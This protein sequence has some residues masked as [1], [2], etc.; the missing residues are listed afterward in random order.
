MVVENA[1]CNRLKLPDGFDISELNLK[2]P[3]NSNETALYC[4]E[5]CTEYISMIDFRGNRFLNRVGFQ[6]E[7]NTLNRGDY[8]KRYKRDIFKRCMGFVKVAEDGLVP[9]VIRDGWF[10][11][12]SKDETNKDSFEMIANV[13]GDDLHKFRGWKI[14]S[15]SE[16]SETDKTVLRYCDYWEYTS[17]RMGMLM[18]KRKR[19][20]TYQDT[21]LTVVRD[22]MFIN[23]HLRAGDKRVFKDDYTYGDVSGLNL[24]DLNTQLTVPNDWKAAPEPAGNTLVL[25]RYT[26]TLYKRADLA[27]LQTD[28]IPRQGEVFTC[29]GFFH[30]TLHSD[31][32][33]EIFSNGTDTGTRSIGVRD[34]HVFIIETRVDLNNPDIPIPVFAGNVSQCPYQHEVILPHASMFRV[35]DAPSESIYQYVKTYQEYNVKTKKWEPKHA[36]IR[37]NVINLRLEYLG[38]SPTF[39][40]YISAGPITSQPEVNRLFNRIDE[41]KSSNP[42]HAPEK[43]FVPLHRQ[44]TDYYGGDATPMLAN[45][46]ATRNRLGLSFCVA[47]LSIAAS[48]WDDF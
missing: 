42:R 13:Y 30:T 21:V 22:F 7:D 9:I 16:S 4:N 35:I 38:V 24:E 25:Y 47:L 19:I 33:Y 23:A 1:K 39:N 46:R 37:E 12:V 28:N 6:T 36:T 10:Y 8:D 15:Y 18:P 5:G 43:Q 14:T 34:R 11:A 27:N 20:N 17:P 2:Q 45:P 26:N 31:R 41:Y 40:Q 3:N 48:L 32:F 44:N 29:E